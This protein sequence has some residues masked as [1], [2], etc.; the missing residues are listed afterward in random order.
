MCR[1][2]QYKRKSR[3]RRKAR[4]SRQRPRCNAGR[5]R[6]SAKRRPE[7][8][9][10]GPILGP[11]P[12]PTL[13]AVEDSGP[14]RDEAPSIKGIAVPPL[15]A[16]L[17][18]R[19]LIMVQS[20]LR[21]APE[22]AAGVASLPSSSKAFA[23]TQAAWR[24]LNNERV[25][26]PALAQP[27]REVGRSRVKELNSRFALLVH[28]W[29]KLSFS[30]GKD[31]MAQL[32]HTT[33]IGYELTTAL[34][35]SADDG[36]PLAPMEMHL[37]TANRAISTRDPAP[38]DVPHL[39]QV[40]PTM[41][42]SR[43]WKLDKSL[44]HVI[45]RE[46]DSVDHFRQ[47]DAAG[48]K[49]LV[50]ADDR[51][52]RVDWCGQSLLLSEIRKPLAQRNAFSKVTDEASYHGRAAQLWVAE[53]RVILYR[54]AKKN[55]GGKRFERAG[56]NLTLRYIIVQLRDSN[57]RVLAEWMLLTNAP[58][59]VHPEHLARCYYWRWR[60]ESYFKLLKSH[61]QQLEQWQQQSGPA[62][63]RRLLVASMACV[64][65]WQL[66]ADDSPQA[67]QLKE[68]VI[69]LSGRQMKRKRPHT[70]PALLAGLWVLLS[71]LE[72]LEHYDLDELRRLAAE[73]SLLGRR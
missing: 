62:I 2:A 34:M 68:I 11:I 70:A 54:P 36:S 40:L 21:S 65:V 1:S 8:E 44:L 56:R 13:E 25:E 45:D 7:I 5:R 29:S 27:L 30:F 55:V 42:A 26:L 22:L 17:Q 12:A 58:K 6:P 51:R 64:V 60:I 10:V 47:W 32:T 15:E 57:G 48:F 49:F 53:T 67:V 33:D 38:A 20:H 4:G 16:R 73:N 72:L 50:R 46:A 59:R 37:K 66:Q 9:I 14:L 71:M 23:A 63:A 3:K 43:G 31:D 28:D 69:R 19:Y 39:D 18:R 52:V 61:G 35:V 41:E 24:F